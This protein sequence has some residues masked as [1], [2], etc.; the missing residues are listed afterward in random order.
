ML[1]AINIGVNP[2]AFT[3]GSF[4]IGWYGIMVALAVVTVV[5]WALYSARRDPNVTYDNVIN[6]ALIGIPSGVIFARLLHVI[7]YWEH[8]MENPG[9]I[10]GGE[11]LTIY[12]AVLG[13]AIG[14]FIYS[15]ISKKSFGRMADLLA[16]GII[17]SQ[18]VGRIGCTLNGCCHGVATDLPWAFVYTHPLSDAAIGIAVHPVPLYEIIFNVL[19]FAGLLMLRGRLKPEGSLFM[20]YLAVYGAWRLG[21]DFIREGRDLLFGLHEAQLIGI[22]V[23]IICA[24]LFIV[25]RTRWVER[26]EGPEEAEPAPELSTADTGETD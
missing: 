4:T 24:V 1:A 13:A 22:V 5:S 7:D 16:P 19:V 21:I 18:A 10:I 2:V 25:R 3:I 20:V 17:L 26:S 12:G 14:V 11:G 23:I 9:S 6:A 8:F 15:R